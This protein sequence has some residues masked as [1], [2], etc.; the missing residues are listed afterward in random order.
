MSAFWTPLILED[1][2]GLPYTLHDPLVYV[3]DRLHCRI[4]V[5]AG[6][7]TDL[8]SIPR[9]L[10]NVLPK[11]GPYDKAAVIHDYLYQTGGR[12]LVLPGKP[13]GQCIDRG[14]ADG[15]LKEAMEV[16]GVG[17]FRRFTIW[18][19]VRIGGWKSWGAYREHER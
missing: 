16:C 9:G 7:K 13:V 1:D 15:V 19:G 17:G 14:D 2:N 6:F 18:S 4:L 3:S 11:S 8:A 12:E 10:W 5:P